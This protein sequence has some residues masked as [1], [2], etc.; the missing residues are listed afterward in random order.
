MEEMITELQRKYNVTVSEDIRA[1]RSFLVFA[2][3][4]KYIETPNENSRAV[5]NAMKSIVA[6]WDNLQK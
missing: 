4:E 5:I 2:G 1:G 6:L 3:H